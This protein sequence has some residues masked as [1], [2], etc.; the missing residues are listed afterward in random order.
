MSDEGCK[1]LD[2]QA[3]FVGDGLNGSS[4]FAPELP[5]QPMVAMGPFMYEK[6]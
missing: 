1:A 6:G 4:H 5:S 2:R 3:Y